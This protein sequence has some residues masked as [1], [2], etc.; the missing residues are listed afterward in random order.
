MCR[1]IVALV[2]IL[3][4]VGTASA[5]LVVRYDFDNGTAN[6]SGSVGAAADGILSV[7]N[8]FTQRWWEPGA[9][10]NGPYPSY[11][12]AVADGHV[13]PQA[14]ASV[15]ADPG[16]NPFP[17]QP[18][19]EPS[20][21]LDVS[22]RDGWMTT[23][24]QGS[25]LPNGP[26]TVATWY[27]ATSGTGAFNAILGSGR[28]NSQDGGF[29]LGNKGGAGMNDVNWQTAQVGGSGGVYSGQGDTMMPG[30]W[31]HIVATYDGTGTVNIYINGSFANSSSLNGL[32]APILH[33][34]FLIGG[35]GAT[36]N[37]YA[38][39]DRRGSFLVDDVRIYDTVLSA[40]EA[41]AVFAEGLIPE[42]AT[43]AL[44]GLGGLALLRKKR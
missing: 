33:D 22:A 4:F 6:N 18:Q 27:K 11:S 21:V 32:V 1:K 17:F 25:W 43:I 37:Q 35:A 20:L 9:Q 2:L 14:D 10:P 19:K 5:G 8:G 28:G 34:T 42:P 29:Y 3:A 24:G 31:N 23:N 13:Y 41:G 12:D 7:D 16:G 39:I 15:I 26:Y 44:L 40:N 38:D 30:L 36:N